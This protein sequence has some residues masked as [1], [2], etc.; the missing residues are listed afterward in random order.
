MLSM[1]KK[2]FRA[3]FDAIIGKTKGGQ[4]FTRRTRQHLWSALKAIKSGFCTRNY[5]G[6]SRGMEIS[7]ALTKWERSMDHNMHCT[8]FVGDG[9]KVTAL[10]VASHNLLQR[11]VCE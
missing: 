9:N 7:G 11:G 2:T 5:E 10:N 8:T 3:H 4:P 1:H 6:S